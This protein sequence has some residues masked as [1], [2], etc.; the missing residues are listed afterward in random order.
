MKPNKN[1][2][3][4]LFHASRRVAAN[5]WLNAFHR[6]T[7]QIGVT[8]SYGKTSTTHALYHIIKRHMPIVMTDLN[9]DTIY[10]VPITALKLRGERVLLLELGIDQRNEMSFHLEIARPNISII[11]GI[12]PVHADEEHL[13]SLENIIIEKR[14][15]IETLDESGI[16]VL[17]FDNA[18]VRAMVPFTRGR[19]VSYG[20]TPD[21]DYHMTD[22]HLTTSGS[23]FQAVTPTDAF[24]ISTPLLGTH[25]CVNLMGA[26]ATAI[27]LGVPVETIQQAAASLKPLGGRLNIEPGP[28]GTTLINDALRANPASTK[29]GLAFL[30][31]LSSSGKKIAVVGEMGELGDVAVEEHTSVGQFAAECDLSLLITVGD[32]TRHTAQAA[33]DSGMAEKNVFA[34]KNVHEAAALLKT[35][36]G[37]G[38]LV[39]LKGSLMRHMERIPMLLNGEIIACN[40]VF[41]PFYHQCSACEYRT[42]GYQN[43]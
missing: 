3:K 42:T 17:N 4:A 38:D 31:E 23:S 8:G 40:V 1:P 16:A 36:A 5:I 15:L 11:T 25:N 28:L 7:T 26:I 35:H 33:Q 24:P 6:A 19:V 21:C 12:A 18:H 10:N 20:S 29:A 2:V 9:L 34:A 30:S 13:G 43:R 27:Q 32:L 22:V 39:Y 41:C 37:E 14:K